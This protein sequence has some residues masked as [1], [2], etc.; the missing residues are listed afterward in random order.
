M[1]NMYLSFD[2]MLKPRSE[3]CGALAQETE[4][5]NVCGEELARLSTT[6]VC[7]GNLNLPLGVFAVPVPR[8]PVLFRHERVCPEW[9]QLTPLLPWD[10]SPQKNSP[11]WTVC[12]W[13]TA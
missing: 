8:S 5:K 9:R 7:V 1:C 6:S 10:F 12:R 2:E 3:M 13:R 4:R 11:V